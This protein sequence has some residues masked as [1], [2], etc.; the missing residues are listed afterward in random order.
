M[1]K[2]DGDKEDRK[3][4]RNNNDKRADPSSDSQPL[5]LACPYLKRKLSKLGGHKNLHWSGLAWC[6]PGKVLHPEL[7]KPS[8]AFDS[9]TQFSGNT[10]T[11]FTLYHPNA[12]TAA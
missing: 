7:V 2:D 5:R 4:K 6:P 11:G 3:D 9:Y 12:R 1:D 8:P 10:Y